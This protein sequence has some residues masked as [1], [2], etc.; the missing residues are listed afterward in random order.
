MQINTPKEFLWELLFFLSKKQFWISDKTF[1]FVQRFKSKFSFKKENRR[2]NTR[3]FRRQF[4]KIQSQK[5]SAQSKALGNK[6]NLNSEKKLLGPVMY[7]DF[8]SSWNT[9]KI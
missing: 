5:F 7:Q 1:F 8:V 3:I 9:F 2:K 6:C 4:G